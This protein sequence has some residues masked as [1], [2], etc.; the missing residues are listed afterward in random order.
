MVYQPGLKWSIL[1]SAQMTTFG[2]KIWPDGFW[3]ERLYDSC[4]F[5]EVIHDADVVSERGVVAGS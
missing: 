2:F 4:F 1:R 3:Q 5:T